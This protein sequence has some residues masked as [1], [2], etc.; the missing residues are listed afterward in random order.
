MSTPKSTEENI[1]YY[2]EAI[3]DA[4]KQNSINF[5]AWF[6]GGTTIREIINSGYKDFFSSIIKNTIYEKTKQNS[7]ELIALDLGCGGGRVM[8]AA[9]KYFKEIIGLDI[10]D[11]LSE[12]E[13][14]L[15][16]ENNN[17][18][19]KKIINNQFPLVDNSI[20]IVYSFIVLQHI[21]KFDCFLA[22][23]KEVER[24]LKSGGRAILYYGRPRLITKKIF[25]NTMINKLGLLVDKIFFEN[26]YLNLFKKGF[27][28]CP[29]APVNHVNL[30]VSKKKIRSLCKEAGFIIEAEG[31]SYKK[32]GYGTQYYTI[33][34][35]P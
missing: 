25:S 27:K 28:E 19:I 1:K 2:S 22:Y 20:D 3:Q 26:L 35:K 12:T 23:I 6:N 32:T 29:Q 5:F 8:N 14:F 24:V 33:F 11:N 7:K 4:A 15:K 9:C 31:I 21:L 13:N 18:Q 30:M 34:V 10:H 17:F 16:Q